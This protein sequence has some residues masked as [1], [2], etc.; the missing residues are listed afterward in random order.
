MF[1]ANEINKR[2]KQSLSKSSTSDSVK[3]P[4]LK[5]LVSGKQRL[6][7]NDYLQTKIKTF[8]N[9]DTFLKNY[10]CSEV[11]KIFKN[12]ET[13]EDAAAKLNL[14]QDSIDVKKIVDALKYYNVV[15]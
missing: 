11:V 6:T 2:L 4:V 9:V 7:N 15:Y 12:S 3:M 10:I 1:D 13:F 8:G 14:C 5:C